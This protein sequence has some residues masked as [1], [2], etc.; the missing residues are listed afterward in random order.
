MLII[1]ILEKNYPPNRFLQ[2][3]F[4]KKKTN[5]EK[6]FSVFFTF[7]PFDT[8]RPE[9]DVKDFFFALPVAF[10]R[11]KFQTSTKISALKR[12]IFQISTKISALKR[13]IFQISTKI[14]ALKTNHHFRLLKME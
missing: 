5:R 8:H 2:I 11:Y 6:I 13:Y 9:V 7:T 3:F 1:I 10:K 14:S 4:V 12:Y